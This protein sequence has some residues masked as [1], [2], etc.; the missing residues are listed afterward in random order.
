M[1]LEQI[2]LTKDYG[3]ELG[4][5]ERYL[6]E[7]G[8]LEQ[9]V[10]TAKFSKRQPKIFLEDETKRLAEIADII[11]LASNQGLKRKYRLGS[12]FTFMGLLPH[13]VIYLLAYFALVPK[14]L[15][16][17]YKAF[18]IVFVIILILLWLFWF[19]LVL[20]S[21]YIKHFLPLMFKD[22]QIKNSTA[23][24]FNSI[25][26][27]I[28]LQPLFWIIFFA[29][30][31]INSSWLLFLNNIINLLITSFTS[32]LI[33]AII[34][35]FATGSILILLYKKIIRKYLLPWLVS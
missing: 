14:N 5:E 9:K 17:Q 15:F 33:T 16:D 4:I 1:L 6:K 24:S 35:I 7:L 23:F 26:I 11:N 22:N 3:E 21:L 27:L 8:E 29:P 31:L 18:Y 34:A 19:N 13:I 10:K 2:Q 12:S 25:F 32:N 30:R 20:N 28:C